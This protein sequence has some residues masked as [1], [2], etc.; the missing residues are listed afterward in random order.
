MKQVRPGPHEPS[1]VV[2]NLVFHLVIV[3]SGAVVLKVLDGLDMAWVY[4]MVP[5]YLIVGIVVRWLVLRRRRRPL[6]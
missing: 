4:V 3:Q 6:G 1:A 5:S 2:Q